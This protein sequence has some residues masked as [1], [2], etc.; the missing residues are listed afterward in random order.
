MST[1]QQKET[2]QYFS[3]YANDWN[4]KA[5]GKK[6][7]KVNVIKQRNDYVLHI[8]N[9][10]QQD[11]QKV[12]TKNVLDI[13]CGTGELVLD[14]AHKKI[15]AL[16]ID[17]APDMIEI[18]NTQKNKLHADHASFSCESIYDT[19]IKSSSY[20][21]LAANG[22]IEYISFSQR[23]ALFKLA[24]KILR[25]N[26]SFVVSSRNR[27]FNLFSANDFTSYEIKNDTANLLLTESIALMNTPIYELLS[28]KTAPLPKKNEKHTHTGIDVTTRYQYTPIQLAK[29]LKKQGF[30]IKSISPVHIH[31]MS[32]NAKENFPELHTAYANA[33]QQHAIDNQ[34]FLPNASAFM[35]HVQK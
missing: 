6:E 2:L 24:H 15:P 12:Q 33:S 32:P 17:F 29:L 14:V 25:P 26:G 4:M 31:G 18:A 34:S 22:F 8:I 10:R 7:H 23:N 30:K 5:R 28:K 16:G 3:N 21:V 19:K 9:Q 27:L 11:A 1:T 13:G 35:I 20:D